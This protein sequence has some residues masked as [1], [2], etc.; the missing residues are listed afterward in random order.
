[1]SFESVYWALNWAYNANRYNMSERI[2]LTG[3]QQGS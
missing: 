3:L 1:M 2:Y